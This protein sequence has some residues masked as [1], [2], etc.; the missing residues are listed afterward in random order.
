MENE[1]LN[2]QHDGVGPQR[3]AVVIPT[4]NSRQTIA[5]TVRACR[6]I[7]L[8]DLIV[9]VDDG[10]T[11]DTGNLAR[12]AGAAVVRHAIARGR[13]SSLETGVKVVSMRDRS[14]WPARL[15]LF[16]DAKLGDS[17]VEAT[18][19]VEAVSSGLADCAIGIPPADEERRPDGISRVASRGIKQTTG[20]NSEWPLS[21]ERCLTR[22]AL[23]A[24][25]PF[26]VGWGA[27]VAMT[28]DLI[29][30]GFSVVE[31][32]C[33][34]RHA[35]IED[36]EQEAYRPP[37]HWEVWLALL[38]RRLMKHRVPLS[39]RMSAN[40]QGVGIPYKRTS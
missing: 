7:P 19:L 22:E 35:P 26:A 20:W 9:V 21:T 23:N 34:F 28:I 37:Q 5:A 4:C 38:L 29:T 25:M 33:S 18:A 14:D 15:L 36:R 30:K 32:P 27:D 31:V 24:V 2:Q 6:A 8:V 16:M 3:V 39:A 1:T 10:S 12:A 13:A 17:A 11:D 40:E